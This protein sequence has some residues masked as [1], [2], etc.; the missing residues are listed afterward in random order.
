MDKLADYY[1]QQFARMK[2]MRVNWERNWEDIAEY[3]LPRKDDVYGVRISGERKYQRLYDSTSIHANELLAS[4]LSSMLVSQ[5]NKWLG[6]ST[7]DEDLDMKPDVRLYMQEVSDIILKTYAHTN[8]Y[9]EVH[10]TFLDL[11]SIGTS[12]LYQGEHPDDDV[13]FRSR[14]IYGFYVAVD[15]Y[16]QISTITYDMRYTYKQLVDEYGEEVLPDDVKNKG[17]QNIMTEFTVIEFIEPN[18]T[19]DPK[20][21][22]VKTNRP[23][24]SIHILQDTKTLV[25]E[26]GYHEMPYAVP[27]WTVCNNEIYGRSPAM[28]AMPDIKMVN[29]M[30]KVVI[31]GAQKVVDPILMVPDNGFLLP[32]DT[33]PGGVNIYRQGMRDRI[34]PLLTQSRPDIGQDLV[35][36]FRQQ[37]KQA[38][39]I[40]QLQLRNGPQMTATEVMQRTEEQLRLMGPI[41]SRFN[42]EML[43]PHI[44]RTFG[45]LQ[46]KGKLPEAPE[47]LRGKDLQI[48]FTSQIAKAQKA[49]QADTL[50]RVVQASSALIET[51]PQVMD[52]FNADWILRNHGDIFGLSEKAFN[53]VEDVQKGRQDQA[54]AAKERELSETQNID[55]D[56]AQKVAGIEGQ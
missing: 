39:F 10:E 18:K 56:T 43:R 12:T 8:F 20:A 42:R 52:N 17:Q 29:A 33:T 28:K 38:F 5:S 3:V 21:P 1:C 13:F 31:R 37:I 23:V 25:R 47:E 36:S 24:R 41:V 30:M 26:S 45:I 2:D 40:D 32:L 49:S 35:E 11:G 44:D 7:G 15:S 34:E 14:P 54:E 50:M 16:K 53:K 55:A 4:A 51:N 19:Y 9:T 27:R 6:F 22:K 46:R 48:R